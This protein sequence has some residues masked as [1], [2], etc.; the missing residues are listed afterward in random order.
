MPS[1]QDVAGTAVR[2]WRRRNVPDGK[3]DSEALRPPRAWGN[4][5]D[6][7]WRFTWTMRFGAGRACNG[8][9]CWPTTSTNCIGSRQRSASTRSRIKVRR[10]P[11]FPI[12]ISRHTNAAAPSREG[13]SRAVATRSSRFCAGHDP[14]MALECV[15]S[16]SGHW[17]SLN[18]PLAEPAWGPDLYCGSGLSGRCS[19][20]TPQ[21]P[22]GL[23]PGQHAFCKRTYCEQRTN[24]V[25][26]PGCCSLLV[27]RIT[28]IRSGS[29][30]Y[31]CATSR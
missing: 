22:R 14:P 7:T 13:Q 24:H 5:A 26:C 31:G 2:V 3:A 11:R 16:H 15:P 12:T 23:I 20:P 17:P 27:F 28:V 4:A 21:R 18:G 30:G 6:G 1:S 8:R 9:I 10:G 25:H 29:N 19:L